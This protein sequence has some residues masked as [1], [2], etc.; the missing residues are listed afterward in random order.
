MQMA[1]DVDRLDEIADRIRQL[2]NMKSPEGF[3]EKI[4][5]LPMLADMASSSLRL[6]PPVPAKK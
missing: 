1:L 4:K 3:L 6:S 2:L 5:M